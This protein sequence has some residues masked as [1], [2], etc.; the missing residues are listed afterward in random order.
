AAIR[1]P[2]VVHKLPTE[3]SSVY[4][5]AHCVKRPRL[6]GSGRSF[7]PFLVKPRARC[8][9]MSFVVLDSAAEEMPVRLHHT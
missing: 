5:P 9:L 6:A 3:Y 7:I 2:P 8:S 1:S 4:F